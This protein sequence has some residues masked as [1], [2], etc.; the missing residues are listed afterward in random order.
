MTPCVLCINDPD[1][2]QWHPCNGCDYENDCSGCQ[3]ITEGFDCNM[4]ERREEKK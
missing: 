4:F 3:V 1:T 2:C